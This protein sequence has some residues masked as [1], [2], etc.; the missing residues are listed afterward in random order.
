MADAGRPRVSFAPPKVVNTA[1]VQQKPLPAPQQQAATINGIPRNWIPAAKTHEYKWIIIHHTATPSGN[2]ARIDVAHRAKG[3]ECAGYDFVVGN[4]TESR[5]GQVEV[6]PRWTYQM[7]GAH[8]S[9][10][11]N[12]Y[13]KWGIGIVLVGNFDTTKPSAKQ[14]QAVEQLTAY[15][16]KTYKISPDRVFGHRDTKAT[17]CPGRYT[18]VAQIRQAATRSLLAEGITF[19]NADQLALLPEDYVPNTDALP[20]NY[21]PNLPRG[22]LLKP[23]DGEE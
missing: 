17:D 14:M 3:W 18:N 21:Q 22:E 16:M 11:D 1:P 2:L 12:R 4:G 6:G 7:V 19:P 5:D 13:N 9:S 15:L 10:P 23:A 8:T 20:A